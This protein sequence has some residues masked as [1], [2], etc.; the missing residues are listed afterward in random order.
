MYKLTTC[1]GVACLLFAAVLALWDDKPPSAA[2][3]AMV[4]PPATPGATSKAITTK[5][6]KEASPAERRASPEV[7]AKMEPASAREAQR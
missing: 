1:L 7:R 5:P 3:S 2:R 6:T 4:S